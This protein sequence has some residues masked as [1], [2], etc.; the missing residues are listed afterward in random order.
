MD[1]GPWTV[2]CG[3][4]TKKLQFMRFQFGIR[5]QVML[6]PEGLQFLALGHLPRPVG[7]GQSP[8]AYGNDVG[9]A[10]AG[11]YGAAWGERHVS[12]THRAHSMQE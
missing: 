12:Q 10:F 6:G 5:R 2:D 8:F 11:R 4:S 3:P 1:Y 7:V 9:A